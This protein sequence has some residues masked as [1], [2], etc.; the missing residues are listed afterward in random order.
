VLDPATKKAGVPWVSFHVFRHTCASIL[1]AEG[2]SPK[3]VQVWLG[4]SDPAFTLRVY[5]HLLDDGL[6]DADFFDRATWAA[7]PQGDLEG[8]ARATRAPRTQASDEIA[9]A[10]EIAV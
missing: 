10:Q 6:G 2:K 9:E 7:N 3:Q 8:N 1:F 5:V 4:H